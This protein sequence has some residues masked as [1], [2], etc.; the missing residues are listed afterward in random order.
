MRHGRSSGGFYVWRP[1]I[2]TRVNCE[3]RPG[4]LPLPITSALLQAYRAA[5]TFL[6]CAASQ[7]PRPRLRAVAG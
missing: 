4:S 6:L 5:L 1:E 2:L 3:W 7:Q